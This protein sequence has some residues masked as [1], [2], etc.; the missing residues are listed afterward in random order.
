MTSSARSVFV[1]SVY[2]I[3]LGATIVVVPNLL[4]SVFGIAPTTE[5]VRYVKKFY[6]IGGGFIVGHKTARDD[7]LVK[8]VEPVPHPFSLGDELLELTRSRTCTIPEL[9]EGNEGAWR[10][11][12]EIDKRLQTMR[13][14]GHDMQSKYKETSTGGLAINITEC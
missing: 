12:A 11:P 3:L 13:Q 6:S 2:L 14:T 9:I 5:V 1:F 4:L 8:D 10:T 7:H